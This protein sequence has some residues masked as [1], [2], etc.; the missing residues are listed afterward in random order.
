MPPPERYGRPRRVSASRG[1]ASRATPQGIGCV[2]T[3]DD[4]RCVAHLVA[5][6][7]TALVES[8]ELRASRDSRVVL[9]RLFGVPY[10][11]CLVV[12]LL[13]EYVE[14]FVRFPPVGMSPRRRP[15]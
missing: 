1:A 12:S 2:S 14:T 8:G 13:F 6:T 5:S 4:A 7:R 11:L 10:A 15:T 3:H 9:S